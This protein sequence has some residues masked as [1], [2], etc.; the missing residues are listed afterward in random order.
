MF[1]RSGEMMTYL[2]ELT[3][4]NA[5]EL[6]SLIKTRQISAVEVIESHLDRI[7][8]L[9]PKINAF[10]TVLY[11]EAMSAAK[12]ADIAVTNGTKLGPLH[13]IPVA[14]KDL[15]PT[16]GIRT[17]RGSRLFKHD[18]PTEDALIVK[19]IKDAGGII[20]GK[21]N[22][23]EFGH[24]GITDNLIFGPTRN[25]WNLERIAGGSSGGS[26]AAVSAG[27]VPLAEGSDG[28]GSIRIPSSMCGVYGFKP[29]FGRVP[30]VSGAF[31]SHSPFFHNGP[32]SRNVT[33]A[34]LFY[35]VLAGSH[36]SD[37]FSIPN[38]QDVLNH[39]DEG[40]KNI[41]IA[42]SSNLGYF[43]IDSDVQHACKQAAETF[44]NL[45]CHVDEVQ[46]DFDQEVEQQFLT[47]WY[48]KL[49]SIYSDLSE[50]EF[51]LL[52]PKVQELINEGKK[53]SAVQYGKANIGREKVWN[54]LLKVYE[55]YDLLICPTTAIPAFSMEKGVPSSINGKEI[56]PLIGWFLTYPFNLT[57][58]PAASIPCGFSKDGLPIGLQIIGRHLD[59]E[60]VFRASRSLERVLS[61]EDANRFAFSI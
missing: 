41:K 25:P 18:V 6:A 29:T 21:T 7:D 24:K 38:E 36:Y 3:K 54:K 40:I 51:M 39:L 48:G 50:E 47:L 43:E 16:K 30:D 60:L 19:R 12:S 34:A 11:D 31:S 37:P 33:D 22:T 23:P 5:I 27:L 42:Y 55:K 44:S 9:N 53:L 20:L 2:D 1:P 46:I 26:S 58:N 52:E 17:T 8:A 13:G 10:C 45:G 57:G 32:I 56:N 61:L 28:A 4:M 49:A 15:T 59:D 14:L 35:Q